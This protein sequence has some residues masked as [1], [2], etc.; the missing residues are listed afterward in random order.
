MFTLCY[1]LVTEQESNQRT[2]PKG[3]LRANAPPLGIPP[4]LRRNIMQIC[5]AAY[6]MQKIGTFSAWTGSRLRCSR[7]YGDAGRGIHKGA[8]LARGSATTQRPL[9]RILLVLFLTKQEKYGNTLVIQNLSTGPVNCGNFLCGKLSSKSA[10]T[11]AC[12]NLWNS[13]QPPVDKNTLSL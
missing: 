9:W 7:G 4:P 6:F 5:C 12:G 10:S 8:S 1:F 13:S 3:A 2:Q 11:H